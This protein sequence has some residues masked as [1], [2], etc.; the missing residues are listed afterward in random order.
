MASEAEI[1]LGRLAVERRLAT[2]EQVLGALRERN[3]DPHGPELGERLVAR[4]LFSGYVLSELRRAL[5]SGPVVSSQARAD[6]STEHALPLGPTREAIARECLR[7]AEDALASD[8]AA[9]LLE[10][11]RLAAEFSDTESGNRA[12]ALLGELEPR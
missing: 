8:R 5:S 2:E 11:R 9:A 3:A 1:K 10:L 12:H 4:G 6:A 7:E